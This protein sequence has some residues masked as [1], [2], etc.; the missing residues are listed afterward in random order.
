MTRSHWP[1]GTSALPRKWPGAIFAHGNGAIETPVGGTR[2]QRGCS[3][4]GEGGARCVARDNVEGGVAAS[5]RH[6]FGVDLPM[7]GVLGFRQR[8]IALECLAGL[9]GAFGLDAAEGR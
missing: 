3:E 4:A 9:V 1:A 2:Q 7:L 8:D 6:H 5:G